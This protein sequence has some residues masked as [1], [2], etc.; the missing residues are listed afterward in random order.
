MPIHSTVL[1]DCSSAERICDGEL[2]KRSP[3]AAFVRLEKSRILKAE[4]SV[5]TADDSEKMGEVPA[6][7][8]PDE[9]LKRNFIAGGELTINAL[10]REE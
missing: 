4:F 9:D 5:T 1:A 8:L 6:R 10:I 3:A 2:C 7:E